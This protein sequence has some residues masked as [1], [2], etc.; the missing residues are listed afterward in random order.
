MVGA[1]DTKEENMKLTTRFELASRST[2]QLR[3]MLRE[4]FNALAASQPDSAEHRNALASQNAIRAELA[5]RPVC[6]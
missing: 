2:P 6:P 4:T 1:S 3:R 5:S